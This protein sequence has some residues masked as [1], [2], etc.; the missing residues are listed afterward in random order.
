[1]LKSESTK[2]LD[3]AFLKAKAKFKPVIKTKTNAFFKGADNKPSK[4]ADLSDVHEATDVAL[5]EE[6]LIVYQPIS[7]KDQI[8][9]VHTELVHADS[10]EFRSSLVEIVAPADAQKFGAMVQYQR[11][12]S[13]SAIL[14]VAPDDDPDAE[15]LT[16]HADKKQAPKPTPKP[17]VN[18]QPSQ[19]TTDPRPGEKP[20]NA[21]TTAAKA[22][23]EKPV[24]DPNRIRTAEEKK[25]DND[26]VR[27]F[28]DPTDPS[29]GEKVKAFII[30]KLGDHKT[31]TKAQ[32]DEV[33]TGLSAAKENN[34]LNELIGVTNV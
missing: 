24:D 13:I 14:G 9:G 19:P 28:A 1:M 21:P 2:L 30:A 3:A 26:K 10:G 7:V 20:S 31:A 32:W 11:R 25:A 29:V 27:S 17:V 15:P 16:D 33:L 12:Y 23:K 8:L 22:G 18:Q 5:R 6:G 34:K 4:Y